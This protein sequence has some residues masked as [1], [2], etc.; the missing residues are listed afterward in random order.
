MIYYNDRSGSKRHYCVP[1]IQHYTPLHIAISSDHE[2]ITE[3]L[4]NQGANPNTI[5]EVCVQSIKMETTCLSNSSWQDGYT[6][7]MT[8][9]EMGAKVLVEYL[10]DAN[11]S[12][13]LEGSVSIII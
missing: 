11:A 1:F 4:I 2:H 13:D 8:A 9:A 10:L 5:S 12:P 3:M 6:P 7:L